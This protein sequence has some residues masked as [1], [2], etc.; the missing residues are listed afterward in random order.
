MPSLSRL[1][2]KYGA[3]TSDTPP[4][5]TFTGHVALS[6]GLL[7]AAFAGY[8]VA[9]N[10]PSK[11]EVEWVKCSDPTAK[12]DK[13]SAKPEK[14]L[15]FY[16]GDKPIDKV[17]QQRLQAQMHTINELMQRYC[18]VMAFFYKHYYA[19]LT[20]SV[21]YSLVALLALFFISKKGWDDA[22]NA[23]INVMITCGGVAIYFTTLSQVFQQREN[24]K[25]SQDLYVAAFTLKHE[26]SS[27]A[28]TRKKKDSPASEIEKDE[29]EIVAQIN[30]IDS[31]IAQ[32]GMIRIGFDPTPVLD[33]TAKIQKAIPAGT[34][35]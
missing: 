35:K 1:L 5:I 31:R 28:A 8:G 34:E 15:M 33:M 32:F 29:A 25:I 6:G 11:W 30:A 7:I 27:F 18:N 12:N 3:I 19:S 24:L 17:Y 14:D 10:I 2:S 9:V 16:D 21:G 4:K 13:S 20:V 26:L 22:N 23:L